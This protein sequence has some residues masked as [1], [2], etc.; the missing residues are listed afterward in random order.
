M[1]DIIDAACSYSHSALEKMTTRKLSP[2]KKD[3][4]TQFYV[5][6]LK[7]MDFNMMSEKIFRSTIIKLLVAPEKKLKGL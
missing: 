2:Q 7:N 6:E 3:R 1:V 4:E 5:T